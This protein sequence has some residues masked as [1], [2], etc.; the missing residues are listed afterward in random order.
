M[1]ICLPRVGAC[2]W[3]GGSSSRWRWSW[4]WSWSCL[5]WF[6]EGQWARALELALGPHEGAGGKEEGGG[7]R[8]S[9]N[10]STHRPP[11]QHHQPPP[12]ETPSLGH[13]DLQQGARVKHRRGRHRRRWPCR[14]RVVVR[15]P[16]AKAE[17]LLASCEVLDIL[18]CG[19]TLWRRRQDG[20]RTD[21]DGEGPSPN[22]GDIH[23]HHAL[24]L[25][26][27]ATP[28]RHFP[29]PTPPQR[30][31]IVHSRRTVTQRSSPGRCLAIPA[32]SI[33]CHAPTA[34][35]GFCSSGV[36]ISSTSFDTCEPEGRLEG[37]TYRA[38]PQS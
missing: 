4:C 14:V 18:C 11:H 31:P 5:W 17:G 2:P 35:R 34:S 29:P 15:H 37:Y 38:L 20:D 13:A 33:V 23:T 25:P 1:G 12:A 19:R 26:P 3:W 24:P 27:T 28:R 6:F 22:T 7:E 30:T 8:S 36:A 9:T 16:L 10:T 21:R 32:S